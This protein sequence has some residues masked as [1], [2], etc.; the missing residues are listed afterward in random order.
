MMISKQLL[1]AYSAEKCH[2]R[3]DDFIFREGQTAHYYYQIISGE[4]KM[5]NFNAEGKEFIQAIFSAGRSFGEPPLF[6]DFVYP[7]NAL[8]LGEVFIYRLAKKRFFELIKAYPE[9]HLKLT[10]ALS[11]RLYYKAIMATELSFEEAGHRILRFL[12]YLKKRFIKSM[13]LSHSKSG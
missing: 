11:A 5:N 9:V 10:K 6:G 3:K 13:P 1:H 8:A 2:Y 4:V 12:D 7:A